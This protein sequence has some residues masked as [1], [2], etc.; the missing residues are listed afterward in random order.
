MFQ[1]FS[2]VAFVSAFMKL[3]YT[4]ASLFSFSR[5]IKSL[6]GPTKQGIKLAS[7]NGI[8][9]FISFILFLLSV[10]QTSW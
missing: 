6:T 5:V 10:V 7:V 2:K 3:Y 8:L 4:L 9:L 1:V